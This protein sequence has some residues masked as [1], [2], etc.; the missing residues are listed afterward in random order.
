VVDENGQPLPSE[1]HNEGPDGGQ[2]YQP[3]Y[4]VITQPDQ[5][6]IYEELTVDPQGLF[7]SSFVS[8]C[9]NIK[10]NRLLPDGWSETPPGFPD[11]DASAPSFPLNEP[12]IANSDCEGET[13]LEATFPRGTENDS[14]YSQG[15]GDT[16][17]YEVLLSDLPEGFAAGSVIA[18]LYYQ[19]I[20]PN[21]LAD[22]F[23][24]GR[25]GGGEE[26]TDAERLYY[27]SSN[28]NVEGTY[29]EDWKLL[30]G[31][32]SQPVS[33]LSGDGEEASAFNNEAISLFLMSFISM[34]F[35]GIVVVKKR[36]S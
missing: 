21:Y 30:V 34:M 16:I 20:P 7:T 28:L 22:R 33:E 1:F 17:T 36:N 24:V 13:S 11:Y 5:V 31:S 12:T 10:D 29:I 2:S 25:Q 3:H 4:E 19:A 23:E 18:R 15:G 14:D 27:L 8:R 6:Q 9:R 35:L 32:A 26:L